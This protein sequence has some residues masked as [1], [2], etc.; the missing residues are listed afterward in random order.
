MARWLAIS[1]AAVMNVSVGATDPS[2]AKLD[3]AWAELEK[4]T[5]QLLGQEGQR[6]VVDMAY[7]EIATDACGGLTL[8]Q[9][10]MTEGFDQLAEAGNKATA[11][12]QSYE[13]GMMA[14]FGVYTG[15][16][17][18]ESFLDKRSFCDGVERAK[19]RKGGPSRFW[20]SQ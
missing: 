18:A 16:I 3:P 4:K 5:T 2:V 13:R 7:A 1:L 17:L 10:A 8:N 14:Y 11:G 19:V 6:Q 20:T 9:K 12:R 15:L